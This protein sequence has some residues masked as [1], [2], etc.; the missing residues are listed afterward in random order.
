MQNEDG[1]IK[2][3][4]E[5]EEDTSIAAG[6]DE[7]DDAD[8]GDDGGVPGS[9]AD[10]AGDDD[11]SV[12]EDG[13]PR[14][15]KKR[16]DPEKRINQL[17]AKLKEKDE[18]LTRLNDRISGLERHTEES[19]TRQRAAV[20]EQRERQAKAKRDELQR[21]YTEAVEAGDSENQGKLLTD[22]MDAT[23]TVRDI[24]RA[25]KANTQRPVQSGQQQ[26]QQQQRQQYAQNVREPPA[27]AKAWFERNKSW[28]GESGDQELTQTALRINSA[29]LSEGWD[30][31]SSD[32]YQEL[33][34]RVNAYAKRK[35][36]GGTVAPATR[37]APNSSGR[38][39]LTKG[40]AEKAR[41]LGVPLDRYAA[42]VAK[43]QREGKL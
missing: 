39:R 28:F 14:K 7:D 6:V 5:D 36:G 11:A 34:R 3:E 20:M 9:D 25:R 27:P 29:L 30:D 22:L 40:M 32:Y 26:P 16:S 35:R 18:L 15:K 13:R 4:I 12:G 17:V 31:K 43:L 19:Q 8:S 10:D 42:E 1:E 38:V 37:Q 24:E 23:Q 33:D 2:Y 41:K 21:K